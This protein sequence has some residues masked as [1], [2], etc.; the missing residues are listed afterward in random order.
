VAKT[1]DDAFSR[2]DAISDNGRQTDKHT[3]S[4]CSLCTSM[5]VKNTR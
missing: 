5:R 1:L 2:F 3:D 4:I